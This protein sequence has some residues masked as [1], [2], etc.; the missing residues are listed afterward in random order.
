MVSHC[1]A[2]CLWVG[3]SGAQP[4][5]G[6]LASMRE[7]VAVFLAFLISSA[8]AA[9]ASALFCDGMPMLQS[10]PKGSRDHACCK[11]GTPRT[12]PCP[13]KNF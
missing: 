5:Q 10:T 13:K 1:P 9:A 3:R 2:K 11:S 8:R 7:I 12:T 4:E 6:A